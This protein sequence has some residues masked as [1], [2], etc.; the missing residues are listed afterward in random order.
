MLKI[1]KESLTQNV[2]IPLWLF[3]PYSY[4]ATIGVILGGLLWVG[5]RNNYKK[6]K[7]EEEEE[8]P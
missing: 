3:V 6:Y 1:I 4:A 7:E 5:C 2:E 8:E